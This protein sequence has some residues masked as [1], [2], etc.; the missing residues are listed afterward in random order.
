MLARVK[1]RRMKKI[2]IVQ[3]IATLVLITLIFAGCKR[4]DF[5][6]IATG[7][8]SPELAVPIGS[9]KFSVTDVL[10]S[11]DTSNLIAVDNQG[12]LKLVY[13]ADFDLLNISDVAKLDDQEV[14]FNHTALE[15]GI[16]PS[17][18]FFGSTTVLVDETFDFNSQNGEKLYSIEFQNGF[19]VVSVATSLQH[20][21]S[22]DLDFPDLT[23]GGSPVSVHIELNNPQIG[24]TQTG[25]DSVNL[26]NSVMD[27]DNGTQGY[28]QFKTTGSITI[29]GTGAP[30][31]GTESVDFSLKMSNLQPDIIYADFGQQTIDPFAD[32]IDLKIFNN[33]LNGTIEFTNPTINFRVT[34]SFGIPLE[35]N[36]NEI[37]TIENSGAQNS[38]ISSALDL[39]VAGTATPGSSATSLLTLDASNTQ[40]L[41][42]IISPA[43]KK[44]VFELAGGLNP[45]GPANNFVTSSSE[46]YV[47]ADIDLPLEGYATNFQ[48][49]DTIPF[50]LE[51]PAQIEEA[52]L[53][54]IINNGF[55]IE[56]GT[57][58]YIADENY[59]ILGQ[60]QTGSGNIVE[61]APVNSAGKVVSKAK[62]IN[63]IVLSQEDAENLKET[64]YLIIVAS[65]QTTD[66][67]V[68]K[69][70]KFYDS[71]EI[72]VKLAAQIKGA[73]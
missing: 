61:P 60:I 1:T 50:N 64:A 15:Y 40:N 23:I 34:N 11:K 57:E 10:A 52:M 19:L 54:L 13:S 22:F 29:T 14:E 39:L 26:N 18:G 27:L 21:V 2:K 63:D 31:T 48:L 43:P 3:G 38:L 51:L 37:K 35:L 49:R 4:T 66:G 12:A 16:S 68:G 9:A 17:F 32:T 62:A 59:N 56:V 42:S 30:I 67:D 44:L 36:I 71:Y 72:E 53:R 8:F 70:V 6:K 41:G 28:N 69:V 20:E 25:K 47:Q 24:M 46:L 7:A 5:S 45:A 73:F 65:C 33:F 55:P 58:L